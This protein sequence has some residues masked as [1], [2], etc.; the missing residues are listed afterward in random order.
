[1]IRKYNDYD[2][3][4]KKKEKKE[5]DEKLNIRIRNAKSIINNNCPRSYDI[6]K[7]RIN[8]SHIYDDISKKVYNKFM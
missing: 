5:Q 7:K 6:F 3:I 2:D 1:M 8:K 4:L